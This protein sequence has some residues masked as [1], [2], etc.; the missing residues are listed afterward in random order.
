METNDNTN[1]E[2]ENVSGYRPLQPLGKHSKGYV[3]N[4]AQSSDAP[5]F[6]G[7][8]PAG[9]APTTRM[10]AV[11]PDQSAAEA[12]PGQAPVYPAPINNV[13]YG[14]AA[15]GKGSASFAMPGTHKAHRSKKPFIII[16]V[17]I[18]LLLI[19][20]AGVAVY[21]TFHF[22]PNT[23]IGNSDVSLMSAADAESTVS[24]VV[25]GYQFSLEGQGLELVLKGSDLISAQSF[26]EVSRAAMAAENPWAWPLEVTKQH[27]ETAKLSLAFNESKVKQVV[28][29]AVE[30]HN[31]SAAPPVNANIAFDE[32]KASYV[33]KPEEIGSTLQVD[34]V[35]DDAAKAVSTLASSMTVD[36]SYLKKPT[37]TSA[38]QRLTAA[39]ESAN[40]MAAAN[41]ALMMGK[42]TAATVNASLVSKWIKLGEDFSVTFDEGALT[43]WVADVAKACN[44]V[45]TT[46][47][48]TRPDGKMFTVSGSVYGWEVQQDELLTQVKEG[49][50]AGR[51]DPLVVPCGAKGDAYNGPGQRDWGNRYMDVDLTEQHARLYDETGA[52]IWESD[53][54]TGMPDGEHDTPQGVYWVNRKASPSTLSG[55]QG[56]VNTYNTEVQYWMPFV[57]DAIGFHDAEWQTA[58]GGTRYK[59]GAGS[60]GCVNLPPE[61]AK[62]LYGLLVEADTVVC[63]F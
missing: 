25:N 53:I 1:G 47:S 49:V 10:P 61:K 55:Y 3:Q 39:V 63:H 56:D 44:T 6:S 5:K 22:M 17:L 4:H 48:A 18:A 26:T 9:Q 46:R 28:R 33:V 50:K 23:K 57:G 31:T 42:D 41:F 2:P 15:A 40:S 35:V 38:D 7:D 43:A 34:A 20:Y 19:A 29:A 21:F 8:A 36:E 30:T 27:D 60:H 13:R 37:V 52:L 12:Q 59:D 45:G 58:F 14:Q 16:G 32:A 54:V 24:T 62:E 51:T 11:S